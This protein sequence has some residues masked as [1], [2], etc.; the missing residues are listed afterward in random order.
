MHTNR[1]RW[2][3]RQIASAMVNRTPRAQDFR[4]EVGPGGGKS[5]GEPPRACLNKNAPAG[6][7]ATE[8]HQPGVESMYVPTIIIPA[9]CHWDQ[10]FEL[11][12]QLCSVPQDRHAKPAQEARPRVPSCSTVRGICSSSCFAALDA[13]GDSAIVKAIVA[14]MRRVAPPRNQGHYNRYCLFHRT[15]P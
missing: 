13:N 9:T 4:E 7:A 10:R 14:A 2:F 6:L 15:P 3:Y 8:G 1:T 5:P 12:V 11:D